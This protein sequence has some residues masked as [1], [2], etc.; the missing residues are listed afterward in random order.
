M[1]SDFI[2]Y[3]IG[4]S[5]IAKIPVPVVEAVTVKLGPYLGPN[6]VLK[7]GPKVSSLVWARLGLK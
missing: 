3:V 7:A 6:P 2:K 5:N 1:G 4:T